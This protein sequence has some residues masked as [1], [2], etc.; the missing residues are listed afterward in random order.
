M[1]G[2]KYGDIEYNLSV[3][4]ALKEVLEDNNKVN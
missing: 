1:A 3:N 4:N 2:K